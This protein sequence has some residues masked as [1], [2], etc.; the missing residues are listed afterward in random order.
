MGQQAKLGI[1]HTGQGRGAKGPM[2]D[3]VGPE[4]KQLIS[5]QT[6]ESPNTNE[7]Q[8]RNRAAKDH[9]HDREEG[10]GRA[11]AGREARAMIL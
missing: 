2:V 1:E 9:V 10:R 3:G 7:Q 8:C 6:S 5:H 11:F 4:G